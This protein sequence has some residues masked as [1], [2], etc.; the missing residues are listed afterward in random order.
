MKARIFEELGCLLS[1]PYRRYN[2]NEVFEKYDQYDCFKQ[3][4]S[5]L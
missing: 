3:N 5:L 2:S 4:F 1:K